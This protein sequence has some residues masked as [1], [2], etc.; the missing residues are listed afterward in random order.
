MTIS[1]H[2][3]FHQ[4]WRMDHRM[5]VRLQYA[6]DRSVTV[7]VKSVQGEN[8]H[9]VILDRDFDAVIE[10]LNLP[11][12]ATPIGP[13]DSYGMTT[14]S[15]PHVETSN[16]VYVPDPLLSAVTLNILQN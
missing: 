4:N 6:G 13:R 16:H 3:E 7:A 8:L 2:L 12:A 5:V 9:G 15:L 11:Q 14:F 10:L 1:S